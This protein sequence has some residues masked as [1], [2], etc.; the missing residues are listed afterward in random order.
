MTL[1]GQRPDNPPL[2]IAIATERGRHGGPVTAQVAATLHSW[3]T[4]L[5]RTATHEAERRD[6]VRSVAI[7][8]IGARVGQVHSGGQSWP[9]AL[10]V[11]DIAV[12]SLV[13]R[14]WTAVTDD[15]TTAAYPLFPTMKP[16]YLGPSAI[17]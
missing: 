8:R 12:L 4:R 13:T 2:R 3:R 15:D 16:G 7:E 14:N 9:A 10:D 6:G 11:R 5:T 1:C 17:G